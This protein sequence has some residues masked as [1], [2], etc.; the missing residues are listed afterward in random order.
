MA[1]GRIP[2]VLTGPN[3]A[4]ETVAGHAAASA[5]ALEDYNAALALQ[6]LLNV[7]LF[8]VYTNEDVIGCELRRAQKH[9]R[10]RRRDG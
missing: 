1:P 8:R 4:R 7:G 5:L 10:H 6:P 3:L 9:H 2:G